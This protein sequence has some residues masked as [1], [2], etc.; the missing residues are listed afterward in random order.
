MVGSHGHTDEYM[1]SKPA[2]ASKTRQTPAAVK[3]CNRGRVGLKTEG[4]SD[5][6]CM[7]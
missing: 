2:L 1:I 4:L 6:A 7:A 5:T 3:A